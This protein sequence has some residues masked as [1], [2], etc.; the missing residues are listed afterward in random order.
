MQ[1][2]CNRM[3]HVFAV[4]WGTFLKSRRYQTEEVPHSSNGVGTS[5]CH[6]ISSPYPSS[7]H[8]FPEYPSSK[9]KFQI[10]MLRSQLANSML[11]AAPRNRGGI[12]QRKSLIVLMALAPLVIVSLL[13]IHHRSTNF[14]EYPSSKHKFQISMLRSQLANSMLHAAP[15]NRG[16]INQ[17][18]SL[19]VLMALAPLVIVSLLRIHHRSTNFPEYPSS[20]H[21]FQISKLRSQLANSM[22]HAA[23]RNRGGIN[24]R[25]SLIVLMALAPL[26]IVSLLRIHHRSTNFPE[27]P[28]SKH[29]FQI[30]MLRSQLASSMLHA[31]PRNRGGIN[32]RKSLIVLM[33]L[34]PL[35]IVS[36][37]RIHHRSTNFP[38]YPSSKHKFQISMLRS[39]LANSMLHAASRNRG[40]INQR[41]SLIVLMALAPLVIVSHLRIHHRSTNF[42][43]L[44]NSFNLYI[45]VQSLVQCPYFASFV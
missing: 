44:E 17:R 30:S 12:N 21:K 8:N 19:I 2:F 38:E 29:K 27:Y 37:L 26:V 36:L 9:H 28:S 6:C 34:A 22:L 4:L 40:G 33:A 31:A 16:G 41:K 32:Q 24:Q 23:P 39:Q 1:W 45:E 7:K 18:K 14:P 25:K 11:H 43:S 35:V 42:P 3:L 13:R 20:K 15:R 5:F 10:S